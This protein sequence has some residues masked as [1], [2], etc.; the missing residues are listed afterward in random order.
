[1][2][3]EFIP[4][5]IEIVI[6]D[7]NDDGWKQNAGNKFPAMKAAM[8]RRTPKFD[9]QQNIPIYYFSLRSILSCAG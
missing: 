2:S 8:N 7:K 5:D 3:R 1:V 6:S 9:P 4:C